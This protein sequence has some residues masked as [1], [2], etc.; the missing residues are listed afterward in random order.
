LINGK[1]AL[2]ISSNLCYADT[3]VRSTTKS[4]LEDALKAAKVL[5]EE[6]QFE[7]AEELVALVEDYQTP[8]L[9][10]EQKKVVKERLSMPRTH[11]LREDFL[12]M[13]RRYNPT[14]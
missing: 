14:L 13:L 6:M 2:H 3:M 10:P 7:L 5:P 9:T 12:A 11:I 8:G 4:T 1:T